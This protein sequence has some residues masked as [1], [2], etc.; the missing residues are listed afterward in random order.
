MASSDRG[1]R[2]SVE[3]RKFI[4]ARKSDGLSVQRIKSELKKCLLIDV[5]RQTIYNIVSHGSLVRRRSTN[6]GNATKIRPVHMRFL[7]IW[8]SKNNE[9]TSKDIVDKLRSTFGVGISHG[10]ARIIRRKLGWMKST[11]KYCQLISN[12]NKAARKAWCC[13]AWH[14]R[15]TFEDV[16]FCDESSIEMN[17]NGR[18][19]FHRERS[20]GFSKTT[21]KRSKP[22]HSYKVNVWA[23][24]SY[25]GRTPIC[26]FTGI[27]D[28]VIFQQIL[29][30]NLLPFVQRE[31]IDGFRL[32]QDN[33]SKH[34]SR[35]TQEWMRQV[36]ILDTV[37]KTPASSPDLNPIENV[38]ASLKLH[39][40]TKVKPKRKEDLVRGIQEFWKSLTPE[41]CRKYIEHIHK[42]I[43]HVILNNGDPTD[44]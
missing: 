36:G 44:F 3:T 28:S 6:G 16:I 2:L 29:Q 10:Y 9:L 14:R 1:K 33:D 26:I 13:D 22:K 5:S 31:F 34:N 38:W 27:M 17:S 19:F 39:L 25:R 30:D 15:D 37:M 43:P 18:L 23:G 11:G 12:K 35:S 7:N 20:A 40:Q 42:V 21:T 41:S 8:L 32:Y 24:I 4:L